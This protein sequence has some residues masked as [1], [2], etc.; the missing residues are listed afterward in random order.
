[1]IFGEVGRVATDK[2]VTLRAQWLGRILREM[3]ERKGLVLREVAEYLQRTVSTVSRCEQGIYPIRR[4]DA[5][6]LLDL[7]GIDDQRQREAV[8]Q[9][10]SEVWRTGWW[11]RYSSGD[12]WGST[13]DLVWLEDRSHALRMFAT[14]T[15][16]GL[17]Q[18]R[19]YARALMEVANRNRAKSEIDQWVELRME[20]QGVLERSA[21]P[22]ISVVLDESIVR[23]PVGGPRVMKAQLRRLLAIGERAT[24]D[25][26]VLPFSAGAHA[27]PDG[28]FTLL[29]MSEPFPEVAH[30]ES[31]AGS[32][33]IETDSVDQLVDTYDWLHEHSLSPE[34]SAALIAAV[35]KE[36]G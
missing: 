30:I 14:T 1:M 17:L 6:A 25:I 16:P 9:L 20:R 8:L 28:P 10:A 36:H 21:P 33:Y 4:V 7:Y 19:D 22:T 15:V 3:R 23:R 24:A 11:E 31:P 35:E 34:D 18:T 27:S 26:R 29:K 12:V 2:S 32:L 13:I 5:A